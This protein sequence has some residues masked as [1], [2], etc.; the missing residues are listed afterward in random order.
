MLLL[1]SI[2]L[3]WLYVGLMAPFL[4]GVIIKTKALVVGRVGPPLF[5]PFY[6]LLKL[7]RKQNVYSQTTTFIFRCAPVVV[8]S[9]LLIL[10]LFIPLISQPAPIRFAGDILMF[11]YLLGIGRFFLIASSFDTGFS[12]AGMGASREAFFSCFTEVAFFMNLIILALLAQSISLSQMIGASTPLSWPLFGP[13]LILVVSSLFLILLAENG[14]I[15]VDD[16]ATHLELTMI[17]EVM[18]LDYSGRDLAAMLYGAM[19][20]FLIFAGILVPLLVPVRLGQAFPDLLV[21]TAG[22]IAIAVLVGIIESIMARLRLNRVRHLLLA[23]FAL[24]FFGF[25][26]TLWSRL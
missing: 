13:A 18:I 3:Q 19:L 5:Q 16:P 15:P 1:K 26:V 24:A 22:L 10:S 4:C 6:D 25:I 9:S 2:V 21:F 7:T 14:R 23:A 12:F 8:L 17:H 20:K 11:V